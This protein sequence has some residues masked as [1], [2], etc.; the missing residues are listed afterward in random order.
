MRYGHKG[1][2]PSAARALEKPPSPPSAVT[3]KGVPAFARP[4]P[5]VLPRDARAYAMLPTSEKQLANKK[6]H[7]TQPPNGFGVS[8]KPR[9]AKRPASATCRAGHSNRK[10][11]FVVGGTEKASVQPP[12]PRP[13]SAGPARP[14]PAASP[15]LAAND[16]WAPMCLEMYQPVW[17]H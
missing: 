3:E 1:P 10:H 15:H 17:K 5:P 2:G 6:A 8:S 4:R 16:W 12:P 13:K 11:L 9:A 7:P 14:G